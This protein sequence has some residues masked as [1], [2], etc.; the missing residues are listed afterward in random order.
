MSETTNKIERANQLIKI[1][2][3]LKSKGANRHAQFDE[4]DYYFGFQSND[5]YMDKDAGKINRQLYTTECRQAVIDFAA[6]LHGNLT[7]PTQRWFGIELL[8]SDKG[9]AEFEQWADEAET[10]FYEILNE[11]NFT[12][13]IHEAYL[14]LG[15]FNNLCIY[16]EP[17]AKRSLRYRTR[18]M[19]NVYFSKSPNGEV[20]RVYHYYSLTANQM[21]DTWGDN[22]PEKV[23]VALN[24]NRPEEEFKLV[25]IVERRKK[26]NPKKIDK[27]NMPWASYHVSI[28]DPMV[29]DEGG[30]KEMPFHIAG[31][32]IEDGDTYA[33]GPSFYLIPSARQ[34]DY[35]KVK[36]AQNIEKQLNPLIITSSDDYILPD[37]TSEVNII[38]AD[39]VTGGQPMRKLDISGDPQIAQMAI[40]RELSNIHKGFF[41]DRFSALQGITK[42]MTATE[43]AG[44]IEESTRYLGP[45]VGRLNTML[46]DLL[47]RSFRI[48]L[49]SGEISQPPE[50]LENYKIRFESFLARSQ[51]ANE[52][53]GINQWLMMIQQVAQFKPEV[54]EKVNVMELVDGTADIH[55]IKQK[56][57]VPTDVVIEKQQAQAEAAQQQQ[58]FEQ[59]I[60]LQGGGSGNTPV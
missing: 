60:A 21:Q 46:S 42:E 4:Q 5:V 14:Q 35:Y 26:Y 12:P 19:R 50:G 13:Q 52:L 41:L 33:I 18:N 39:E 7:N 22:I 32:Y 29:V 53:S 3:N 28:D 47:E 40:E 6:G 55:G 31:F 43:T 10:R 23:K 56:Y 17:D 54:V 44:I 48:L 38:I 25:H 34:I 11:T 1:G 37:E 2:E 45:V 30:Y 58:Q 20:D 57:I 24:D 51:R 36:D 16:S 15:K 8:S 27:L 9:N 49:E 59:M